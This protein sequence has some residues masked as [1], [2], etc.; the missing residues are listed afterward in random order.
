MRASDIPEKKREELENT[1]V[2]LSLENSFKFP[3][4][5]RVID[6]FLVE[7]DRFL[8]AVDYY[9]ELEV[10]NIKT[11]EKISRFI[12]NK[13][14]HEGSIERMASDGSHIY[15]QIKGGAFNPN[16]NDV[17]LAKIKNE[18][19]REHGYCEFIG[20][21]IINLSGGDYISTYHPAKEGGIIGRID[22]FSIDEFLSSRVSLVWSPDSFG[23]R[24]PRFLI[25]KDMNSLNELASE[26]G[27]VYGIYN[28]NSGDPFAGGSFKLKNG[29]LF[30]G[31]ISPSGE[32]F[33]KSLFKS[34][35][36]IHIQPRVPKI[37]AGVEIYKLE[38][39][40]EERE[41][42]YFPFEVIFRNGKLEECNARIVNSQFQNGLLHILRE[43]Q[44]YKQLEGSWNVSHPATLNSYKVEIKKLI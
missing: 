10:Y 17:L 15:L 37:Y 32:P 22:S 41:G 12:F 23:E 28:Y 19:D 39:E 24:N 33:E 14:L 4:T 16:K 35:L 6:K 9:G 18:E 31:E 3:I 42:E 30:S 11:G 44:T 25:H 43:Q 8:F 21:K 20:E 29:Q 5:S 1:I 7:R 38:D 2:Q 36:T 34:P 40:F 26:N 13:P 27:Y